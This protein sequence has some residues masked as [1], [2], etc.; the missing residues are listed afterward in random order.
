MA[1]RAQVVTRR[2]LHRMYHQCGNTDTYLSRLCL[3]SPFASLAL[4]TPR[5]SRPRRPTHPSVHDLTTPYSRPLLLFL[6]PTFRLFADFTSPFAF[7][8]FP[9][10]SFVYSRRDKT[11]NS[12][13]VLSGRK[14]V[15]AFPRAIDSPVWFT[16]CR[17]HRGQE[18]EGHGIVGSTCSYAAWLAVFARTPT[19]GRSLRRRRFL[20]TRLC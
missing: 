11:R 16:R 15:I 17:H 6:P 8:I 9:F 10:S 19:R 7:I 3:S 13:G 5:E 1:R 2:I 14:A 4:L 20:V 12:T 18:K